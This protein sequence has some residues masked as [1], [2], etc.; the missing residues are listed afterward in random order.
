MAY[1][2]IRCEMTLPASELGP[3]TVVHTRT[4]SAVFG[5]RYTI[6]AEGR[7]VS[8]LRSRAERIHELV[9]LPASA[10]GA[11]LSHRRRSVQSGHSV[12]LQG[13]DD[14]IAVLLDQRAVARHLKQLST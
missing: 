12:H 14:A 3:D 4:F 2:E 13:F 10:Q 9:T 5:E 1:D 11:L 6:T 8:A 7:L